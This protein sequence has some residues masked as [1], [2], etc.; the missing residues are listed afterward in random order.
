MRKLVVFEWITLDGVFDADTMDQW[1]IPY[2]S[3]DRQQYIQET[4]LTSGGYLMGRTTYEMLAPSWSSLKNN[5]MGIADKFN[6]APKYVICSTPMKADWNNTTVIHENVEQEMKRLQQ[7]NGQHILVIGSATLVESLMQANLID[8][9]RFLVQ[10]VIMGGRGGKRFFKDGMG[11]NRL[12]LVES[13]T[14]SLGVVV[15][16]Y[17]AAKN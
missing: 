1:W 8:E 6:S 14:L 11:M 5:E 3:E 4:Y 9:Y 15:L 16:R 12:K 2:D 10:P 13:K 7:K 17:T